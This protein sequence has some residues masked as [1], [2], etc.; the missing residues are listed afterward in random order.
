MFVLG[1]LASLHVRP[2]QLYVV[3]PCGKA[4]DLPGVTW[5]WRSGPEES[6]RG[7]RSALTLFSTEW[8][9]V[10]KF[11]LRPRINDGPAHH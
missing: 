6:G 4:T 7:D 10:G 8:T 3:I 5:G 1:H 9:L 11:A 2:E